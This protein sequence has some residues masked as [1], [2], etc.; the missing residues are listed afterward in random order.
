M[1]IESGSGAEISDLIYKLKCKCINRDEVIREDVDLSPAEFKVLS[2]LTPEDQVSG[3]VF[4][5]KVELS[6]SR[7]SRVIDKMIEN[8]FLVAARNRE[9]RRG[10]TV[11]LTE[12]GI[13]IH[14]QIE[15]AREHCNTMFEELLDDNERL[16]IA[17]TLKKLANLF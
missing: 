15:E 14:K 12:K 1:I 3:R 11:T 10:I 7:S 17:G 4:A 9:D 5:K 2:S 16:E 6:A 8:G 13:E